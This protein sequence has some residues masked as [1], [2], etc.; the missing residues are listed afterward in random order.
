VRCCCETKS[1]NLFGIAHCLDACCCA[2]H[3]GVLATLSCCAKQHPG[4]MLQQALLQHMVVT[5]Q[6]LQ[7]WCTVQTTT[8]E[9][10]FTPRPAATAQHNVPHD[11]PAFS[12]GPYTQL[13]Q[14]PGTQLLPPTALDSRNPAGSDSITH[15]CCWQQRETAAA[16]PDVLLSNM[17]ATTASHNCTQTSTARRR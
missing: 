1:C 6:L 8:S 13:T 5:C 15:P 12:A 7:R 3:R 9:L 16:Q 14:H 4:R 17:A 2:E 11:T 10:D